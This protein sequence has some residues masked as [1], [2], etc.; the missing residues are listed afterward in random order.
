MLPPPAMPMRISLAALLA[1]A[2]LTAVWIVAP[3]RGVLARPAA[4]QEVP[5]AADLIDAVNALR[6]S[7]GLPALSAHTVLMQVAQWEADMLA[8]S[9]GAYGHMRPPDMTLGQ[10]LLSLG[11]PL[12]GDLTLDGYRSENIVWGPTMAVQDAVTAWGGDFEHTNTML[13]PNRSDVGAAVASAIDEWGATVYY[14]VLE[15][16]LQTNSGRMQSDAY[17]ILTAI[18][19]NRAAYAAGATQSASDGLLP[20][21]VIPVVRS[22]ALPD[23]DVF[24]KVQYGQTLWSIAVTYGSKI[25]QI[26]AWNGLGDTTAIGVGQNLLVQKGATPPPPASATSLPPTTALAPLTPTTAAM[27]P[28][29]TVEP[30]ETGPS[31]RQP[32]PPPFGLWVG[33]LLGVVVLGVFIAAGQIRSTH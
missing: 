1:L 27:L 8:G 11:Y 16:A 22:T 9:E 14:Y 31:E 29:G 15:T 19:S 12:S 18:A 23:G 7:S 3:P 17:P 26:R 13:S 20:Q 28:T 24:H 33:V 2:L 30:A 5:S 10:Q 4:Q 6:L 25:N 21:Y 32:A